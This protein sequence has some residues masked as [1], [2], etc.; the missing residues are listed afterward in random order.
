MNS[1]RKSFKIKNTG[2]FSGK[3]NILSTY[4]VFTS[5]LGNNQGIE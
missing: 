1:F 4:N 5:I 2:Q 3:N